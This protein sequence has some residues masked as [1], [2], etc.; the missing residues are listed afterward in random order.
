MFSRLA[1][2]GPN[3]PKGLTLIELA[4]V[5][6]II[7]VVMAIVFPKLMG[8]GQSRLKGDS[9]KVSTLLGYINEAAITKKVYYRVWFD[10]GQGR[11]RV[12]SSRD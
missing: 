11:L 10:L 8:L 4:V 3:S 7:G 6:L 5:I 9:G 2:P 1:L 12:E